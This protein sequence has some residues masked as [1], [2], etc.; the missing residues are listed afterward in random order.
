MNIHIHIYMYIRLSTPSA[1]SDQSKQRNINNNNNNSNYD[2]DEDSNSEWL[3][4]KKRTLLKEY[5]LAASKYES[6]LAYFK[7]LH[8][9]PIRYI[10][11]N[12]RNSKCI[13]TIPSKYQSISR[14]LNAYPIPVSIYLLSPSRVNFSFLNPPTKEKHQTYALLYQSSFL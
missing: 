5:E 14:F 4:R 9:N 7:V 11:N 12:I 10:P 13:Y 1:S 8:L 3:D 6:N 2:S